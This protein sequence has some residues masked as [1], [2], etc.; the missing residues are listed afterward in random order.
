MDKN[1]SMVRGDTLA[2][3]MQFVDLDQDL[4]TAYFTVRDNGTIVVQKSLGNGISKVETGI[5][6]V[7]IAPDD[8]E[9]LNPGYYSYDLE[10]GVNDDVF[11]ILRGMLN[12]ESDITF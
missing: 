4:D 11:T 3:G 7:R 6:R 12:I 5:Y 10:I 1:I 9:D 8:T 2:F